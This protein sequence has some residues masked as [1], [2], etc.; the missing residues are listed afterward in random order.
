MPLQKRQFNKL[1]SRARAAGLG[2]ARVCECLARGAGGRMQV[3]HAHAPISSVALGTGP[4]LDRDSAQSN[5]IM[6]PNKIISI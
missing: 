1:D 6:I 4:R 3:A 5:I 2:G